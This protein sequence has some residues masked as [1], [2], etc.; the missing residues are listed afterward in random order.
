MDYPIF[1][2]EFRTIAYAITTPNPY[3][4]LNNH[5]IMYMILIII[6][7]FDLKF[8]LIVCFNNDYKF[9]QDCSSS[10]II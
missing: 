1:I 5:N 9:V 7:C 6:Y 10:T 4:C 3:I 8:L 2:S